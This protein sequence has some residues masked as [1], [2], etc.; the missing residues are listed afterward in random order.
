MNLMQQILAT[1]QEAERNNTP[2]EKQKQITKEGFVNKIDADLASEYNTK[3]GQPT[4]QEGGHLFDLHLLGVASPSY[5]AARTLDMLLHS[6]A[7]TSDQSVKLRKSI[8]AQ[9]KV[10][11][12]D[13]AT[14]AA[15]ILYGQVVILNTSFNKYLQLSTLVKTIEQQALYIEMALKCQE[16]SRKTIE[17]LSNIKNPTP[18]TVF[19]KNAI[20]QQVNQLV[21]KTEELQKRFEAQP[22]AAMDTGISSETKRETETIDTPATPLA[23]LDR[24]TE[25]RRKSN[26]RTKRA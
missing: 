8:D 2:R 22:Y 3:V 15:E 5:G 4:K 19:I 18:K 11:M 20:A 17:S 16:Q 1:K 6:H 21:I 9:T 26:S 10:F 23:T 25:S 14:A 12:S 13:E 7:Q 24:G